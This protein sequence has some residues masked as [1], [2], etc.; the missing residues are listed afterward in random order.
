MKFDLDALSRTELE[1]LRINVEK[2]LSNLGERER[3]AALQAAEQA[4][5]AHGFSLKDLTGVAPA[6]VKNRAKNPPKYR[7]PENPSAT[8][9]GRGR[10]PQWIRDAE[11]AGIDIATFAI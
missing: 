6:K 1:K 5:K 4:A 11:S 7:H 9:T 3:N 8:W 2:A 10:K